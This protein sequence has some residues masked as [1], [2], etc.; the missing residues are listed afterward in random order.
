M[1]ASSLEGVERG[2]GHVTHSQPTVEDVKRS[3]KCEET[4]RKCGRCDSTVIRRQ[5]NKNTKT[6][7]T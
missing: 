2:A 4:A 5:R 7:R 6:N 1:G 3:V